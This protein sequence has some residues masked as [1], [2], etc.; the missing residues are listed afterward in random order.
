MNFFEWLLLPFI[1]EYKDLTDTEEKDNNNYFFNDG[2]PCTFDAK[3]IVAPVEVKTE[4]KS[5]IFRP[6]K[7]SDYIG[8]KEA[9]LILQNFISGTRQRGLIFPH[10]LIHGSAGC[11]KTTLVNIISHVLKVPVIE[12][13]TSD[14]SDFAT[15]KQSIDKAQGGI[16]FLDE[17]HSIERNN[18]EKL[19]TIMEDFT[20]NGLAVPQFTLIG[21]TT[22]LGEIIENRRP[23][24]DR[25]KII[26]GLKDY[27]LTDLATIIKQ[28]QEKMF[29]KERL[30]SHIYL[31]IAKNCRGTPRTAIRLLEATIY[32]NGDIAAVLQSFD[33]IEN[34]YTNTDL[35]LLKYLASND[36]TMGMQSISTYLDTSSANYL[37]SIEP[38]L[39][40]TGMLI[41][42]P[43][44]RKISNDGIQLIERLGV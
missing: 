44:G 37:F 21:A 12:T 9:K 6:T 5:S 7:F 22:E 18:A 10:T 38:Y 29:A 27:T 3:P 14:I 1:K 23:F 4:T 11:G 15:L 34:G 24:Y 19:Y 13:I 16:L 8:Q 32:F 20:Y 30:D 26:V 17:I 43:R 35:K 25:F 41:R 31:H 33:I 28:Y 36:H 42:T 40:K 2:T 39:L